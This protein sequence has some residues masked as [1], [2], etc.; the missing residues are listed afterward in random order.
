MMKHKST[1]SSYKDKSVAEAKLGLLLLYSE[2]S[3]SGNK[4]LKY[5]KEQTNVPH[6]N[7]F[8]AF[9]DNSKLALIRVAVPNF[10]ILEK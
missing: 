10:S 1:L 3:T 7:D 4:T 2:K 5:P 8:S 6:K 9:F